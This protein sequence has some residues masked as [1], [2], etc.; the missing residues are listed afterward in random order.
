MDIILTPSR[1]TAGA[2]CL[3]YD[4]MALCVPIRT[5]RPQCGGSA[6]RRTNHRSHVSVLIR[7]LLRLSNLASGILVPIQ[8]L[9]PTSNEIHRQDP[10]HHSTANTVTP[11]CSLSLSLWRRNSVSRFTVSTFVTRS[12]GH[13]QTS[14]NRLTGYPNCTLHDTFIFQKSYCN[15]ICEWRPR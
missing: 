5:A 10:M 11:S 15:Y 14:A 3:L 4:N 6:Q 2:S 7:N 1:D 8:A 9:R 12:S 13:I